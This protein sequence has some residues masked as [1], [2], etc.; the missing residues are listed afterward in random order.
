[1]QINRGKNPQLKQKT[2]QCVSSWLD[3]QEELQ[4]LRLCLP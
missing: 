3:N 2:S 1:M 4:P